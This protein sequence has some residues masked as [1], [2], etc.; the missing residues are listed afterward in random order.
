MR[1]RVKYISFD[2]VIIN[3]FL[4]KRSSSLSPGEVMSYSLDTALMSSSFVVLQLSCLAQ[5]SACLT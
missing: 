5:D 1:W 2:D 4:V 3:S